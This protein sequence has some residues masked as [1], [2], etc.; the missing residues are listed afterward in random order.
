M[1]TP[2]TCENCAEV[3]NELAKLNKKIDKLTNIVTKV[4]KAL[5]I[6]PLSAKEEMDLQLLQRKNMKI[7]AEVSMQLEEM[8]PKD[9]L[10]LPKML[11]VFD[12][13]E[14][15]ELFKDVLGSDV[16]GG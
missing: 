4:G 12:E 10:D 2:H 9:D 13:Y 5:H 6:I 1:E 15:T 8:S 16:L 3:L 11:T 14:P 7:A